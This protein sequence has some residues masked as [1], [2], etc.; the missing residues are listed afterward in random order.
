MTLIT[1]H[2]INV[3]IISCVPYLKKDCLNFK[4]VLDRKILHTEFLEVQYIII[5]AILGRKLMKKSTV[6]DEKYSVSI[7]L[8]DRKK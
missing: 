8:L 7:R 1:D 3:P 5:Q 2:C 4:D 6:T